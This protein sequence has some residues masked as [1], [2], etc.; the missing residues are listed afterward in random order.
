M[1]H[2]ALLAFTTMCR[3]A[4]VQMCRVDCQP[5]LPLCIARDV[6]MCTFA[7]SAFI[8]SVRV[9]LL[10]SRLDNLLENDELPELWN[11]LLPDDE[12]DRRVRAI[13]LS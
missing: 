4:D 11:I 10:R 1:R 5:W 12:Q 6:G 13:S 9:R 7:H 2:N 3:C 8:V